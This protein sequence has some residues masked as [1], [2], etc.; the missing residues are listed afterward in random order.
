MKSVFA[1]NNRKAVGLLIGQELEPKAHNAAKMDK[2]K[3]R[4]KG[5]DLS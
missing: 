5:V 3:Q 2:N 1:E 4:P